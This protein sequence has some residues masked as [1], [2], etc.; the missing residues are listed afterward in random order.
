MVMVLKT[1]R[2]FCS[3]DAQCN[4]RRGEIG[5]RETV[6]I[7][8]MVKALEVGRFL[9]LSRI[10]ELI[11]L[12]SNDKQ[13]NDRLTGDGLAKIIRQ[14]NWQSRGLLLSGIRNWTAPT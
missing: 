14:S 13:K 11:L 9:S 10:R 6:R 7:V 3:F 4:E 5:S 8:R 12:A 2:H 1:A